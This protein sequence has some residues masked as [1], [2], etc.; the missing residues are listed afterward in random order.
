MLSIA[1]PINPRGTDEVVRKRFV[2]ALLASMAAHL[3]LLAGVGLPEFAGNEPDAVPLT[4]RSAPLAPPETPKPKAAP[5]RPKRNAGPSAEPRL[6]SP[7]PVPSV[8]AAP[9]EA[10]IERAAGNEKSSPKAEVVAQAPPASPASPAAPAAPAS[11][12]IPF[13]DHIYLEFDLARNAEQAPLARVVHRFDRDG[14]RYVIRSVT[15]AIGIASLFATGRYVQESRGTLSAEGLRPDLFTVRRGR[16]ERVE[17]A[18]FDWA[19]ARATTSAAGSS[20][21]W[22]L[23]LGAQD[24]LSILHQISF[25][26]GAPP[27]SLMM[28]NGK[29]FYNARIE[30]IGRDTVAT[31]IGPV[32]AL[33]VRSQLEGEL[34]I[35]IWLASDH[36]NLPVKVRFRD[37]KGEE[38]EQVLAAVKAR[39]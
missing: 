22:E 14:A 29:R 26:I 5:P 32:S 38:F 30:I 28:T 2:L 25:L 23:R 20:R 24:Q 4:A 19:V 7:D 3:A 12:N 8:A 37:R 10:P 13:P 18:A 9:A 35:D 11:E 36:G 39:E 15:E 31:G 1:M 17:S 16:A 27:S 21:D 33:Q 34:R 6:A